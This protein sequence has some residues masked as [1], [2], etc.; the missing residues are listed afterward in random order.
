MG[1]GEGGKRGQLPQHRLVLRAELAL[2]FAEGDDRTA[3]ALHAQVEPRRRRARA[4]VRRP[5]TVGPGEPVPQR[6]GLLVAPAA[7]D[8]RPRAARH[9]TARGVGEYLPP[10]RHAPAVNPCAPRARQVSRSPRRLLEHALDGGFGEQALRDVE[11]PLQQAQMCLTHP[12]GALHLGHVQQGEHQPRDLA[13]RILH[14]DQGPVPIGDAALGLV[15]IGKGLGREPHRLARVAHPA[16]Y[17][18]VL[19]VRE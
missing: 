16:E 9:T 3:L 2:P 13:G 19:L 8:R 12:P 18:L 6:G 5:G 4:V 15:R 14:R 11:H 1:Q 7:L 10:C 17:L